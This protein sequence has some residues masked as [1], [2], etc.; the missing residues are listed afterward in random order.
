MKSLCWL[1]K[2]ET[3]QDCID[4]ERLFLSSCF[5]PTH[6]TVCRRLC[7]TAM[8]LSGALV[9]EVEVCGKEFSGTMEEI[10]R[11]IENVEKE[12]SKIVDEAFAPTKL[13]FK[14]LQEA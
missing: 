6:I 3:E 4:M 7:A 9:L 14:G 1:R 13:E 12:I 5:I 10:T 2:D 8:E 11:C